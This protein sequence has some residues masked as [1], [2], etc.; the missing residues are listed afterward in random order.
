MDD[1]RRAEWL[2]G[3]AARIPRLFALIAEDHVESGYVLGE[4]RI[5]ERRVELTL[6]ARV[7]EGAVRQTDTWD[8]LPPLAPPR[9][10]DRAGVPDVDARTDDAATERPAG[11][12]RRSRRGG[13]LG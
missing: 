2:A 6:V 9:A 10:T 3:I 1:S 11:R 12:R 5:G 7:V 4:K 13:P 8:V